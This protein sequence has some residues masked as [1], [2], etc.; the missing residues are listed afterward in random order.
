MENY[1]QADGSFMIPEA[2]QPYVGGKI[3]KQQ[4]PA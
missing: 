2:L 4:P 3:I 1:Q